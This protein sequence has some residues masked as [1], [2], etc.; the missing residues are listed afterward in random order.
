MGANKQ[1]DHQTEA[2]LAVAFLR[3][4]DEYRNDVIAAIYVAFCCEA[5][6]NR[7]ESL[8]CRKYEMS[9]CWKIYIE[10]R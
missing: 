1:L 7:V 3:G 2:S 5:I 6:L 8:L 4:L 10:R 9:P